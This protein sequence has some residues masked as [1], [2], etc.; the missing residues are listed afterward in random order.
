MCF[1]VIHPYIVVIVFFLP[2]N[3]IF[4]IKKPTQF[5]QAFDNGHDTLLLTFGF[6]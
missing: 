5:E 1:Y 3:L 2:C 4:S 6:R